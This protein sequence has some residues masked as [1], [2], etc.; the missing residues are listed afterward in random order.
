MKAMYIVLILILLC[1]TGCSERN[2]SNNKTVS[3]EETTTEA[4][5]VEIHVEPVN[6]VFTDEYF[7]GI[8]NIAHTT[9]KKKVHDKEDI[10]E[11]CSC[12]AGFRLIDTRQLSQ[13]EI[14]ITGSFL[15][16]NYQDGSKKAVNI[17]DYGLLLA[18]GAKNYML[19]DL[20]QYTEYND[21]LVRIFEFDKEE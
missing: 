14:P 17:F 18:T 6:N 20:Q 1:C 5:T 2:N 3:K 15:I 21:I 16:L 13:D 9:A 4:H 19:E 10:E 11:L 8:T 7:K 12:L